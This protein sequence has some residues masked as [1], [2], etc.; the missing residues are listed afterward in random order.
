M[1]VVPEV[2]LPNRLDPPPAAPPKRGLEA[3]VLDPVLELLVALLKRDGADVPEVAAPPKRL[4]F[5]VLL[6][7]FE[8]KLKLDI[9]R[10]VNAGVD[11]RD[12]LCRR[13]GKGGIQVVLLW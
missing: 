4:G 5:G 7:A 12:S 2:A 8:P 13:R 1:E 9:L 10:G 6:P 11:C 3:G